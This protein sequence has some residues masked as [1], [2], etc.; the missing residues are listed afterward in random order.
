MFIKFQL[1]ILI[2]KWRYRLNK[3]KKKR[4]RKDCGWCPTWPI[5]VNG[6]VCSIATAA[7]ESSGTEPWPRIWS[8][9]GAIRSSSPWSAPRRPSSH[10]I[11]LRS[12]IRSMADWTG[13]WC[14]RIASVCGSIAGRW[15]SRAGSITP[16]WLVGSS[17]CI[18]TSRKIW[19]IGRSPLLHFVDLIH[20]NW[21]IFFYRFHVFTF[22]FN[23]LIF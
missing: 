17:S 21:L 2:I 5:L 23:H 20:H 16:Y 14:R 13:S 7:S 6:V 1:I 11:G 8:W 10:V 12:S 22:L 3:K 4:T 19:L 18:I 9:S 15:G